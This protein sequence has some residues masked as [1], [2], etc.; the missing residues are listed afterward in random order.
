MRRTTAGKVWVWMAIF[1][2]NVNGIAGQGRS[3]PAWVG[4]LILAVVFVSVGFNYLTHP[5]KGKP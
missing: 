1:M 3:E 5:V 2:A 4:S